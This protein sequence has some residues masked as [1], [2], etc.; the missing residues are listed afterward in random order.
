MASYRLLQD[1]HIP[2]YGLL[3]AGTIVTDTGPGAQIPIGWKPS[4]AV[5]PISNDAIQAFFNQGPPG[6]A[7][8]CMFL[9]P[10]GIQG[11]WSTAFVAAPTVFWKPFGPGL[12]ILTGAGAALGP[13]QG[14]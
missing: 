9:G 2:P 6:K 8:A 5:D 1:H 11:H 10:Y 7:S 12:W 13:V 3:E 4:F 14:F